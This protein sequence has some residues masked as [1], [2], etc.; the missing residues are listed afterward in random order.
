MLAKGAQLL[1]DL[2]PLLSC[3]VLSHVHLI[4]VYPPVGTW[5]GMASASEFRL[6]GAFFL[7]RLSLSNPFAVAEAIF[8][9]ALHH[10]MYDF[11][12]GHSLLEPGFARKDAPRIHALWN[13]PD[14]KRGHYWNIHRALAAFHVYVHLALLCTVAE[15]RLH[16][17]EKVYGKLGSTTGRHKALARAQFLAEHIRKL[18]WQELG[19]AGKRFVD[20]FASVLDALDS[21][22]P[23]KGSY[24]HLLLDRYR[25]EGNEVELATRI[26]HIENN[27]AVAFGENQPPL[28][29]KLQ[30]LMEFYHVPGLSV[31]VVDHY[32][33]A[34]AKG[35]GV[36]E[37]GSST[38]VTTKTLFQA[39]SIS[40]PVS[41]TGALYLVE[42]GKLSLDENVNQKLRSWKVPDNEFTKNQKVTLRRILSHSAGLT[43]H[44]F[45]GYDVGEPIPTL[46]QILNGEKPSNTG[47]IRVDYVPGSQE[48]YSGGGVTIEQQL[49]IDVTGE[50]FPQFMRETVLDKIG[51][52]NSTYEQPLPRPRAALAASG[53]RADAKVVPGKWRIYPE[54]AA[55]GLWTNPTDLAKFGIEIALSK[56]GKSNRVLSEASTREMLKPQIDHVGLGFFLGDGE[57]PHIFEHGGADDGFQ[58]LFVF[59]DLGQGVVVM[60]NSDNG[61][62]V[63]AYLIRSVAEEYGWNSIQ[64]Q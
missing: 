46:V 19:L 12:Q 59:S 6:S 18:C 39:G 56:H 7:N 57:S 23:P 47:P 35:Y 38:S 61:D 1:G 58:A 5:T 16:E 15:H 8:H 30:K 51:M 63:A 37:P 14:S 43:V 41:A 28:R 32:K 31:A 36:T 3:N 42:S 34:W 10:Q 22:P 13:L 60:T 25:R 54:M 45:P 20:W 48:R 64:S 4:A 49:I 44:G 24:V 27:L 21:S 55:A 40:K 62:K 29:L 9:E 11:R 53:A 33:I 52:S 17:L 50:A 26:Q 2:L